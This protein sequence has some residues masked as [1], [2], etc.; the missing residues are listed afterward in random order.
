MQSLSQEKLPE[1]KVLKDITKLA[2]FAGDFVVAV[3]GPDLEAIFT[4]QGA[5]KLAFSKNTTKKL[6]NINIGGGTSNYAVIQ[7]GIILDTFA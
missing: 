4:A 2:A 5:G 6:I 7:N 3:A 1:K